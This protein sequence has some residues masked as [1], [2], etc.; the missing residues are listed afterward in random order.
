MRGRYGAPFHKQ[1]LWRQKEEEMETIKKV[2]YRVRPITRYIVTRFE[3]E[4]SP[5]SVNCT[6][7][8]STQHGV[9]DSGEVAYQVAYAL[10]RHEHEKSGE[11]LDS[12][13]FKYP[14]IP[15]GVSIPPNIQI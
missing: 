11:P 12:R 15:D 7:G 13:N 1:P 9:F 14:S 5:D 6:A 4:E 8:A 10:C 2:E 3:R